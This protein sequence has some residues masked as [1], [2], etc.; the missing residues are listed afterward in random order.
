MISNYGKPFIPMQ[1]R[2]F[3]STFFLSLQSGMSW[4]YSEVVQVEAC[5]VSLISSKPWQFQ[6][7]G[8]ELIE[9]C[10]NIMPSNWF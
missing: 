8:T 1:N 10:E 3:S 9:I 6:I 5:P 4:D 2:Y 7:L